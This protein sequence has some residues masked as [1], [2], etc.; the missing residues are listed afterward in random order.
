[1][2]LTIIS[3]NVGTG[4]TLLSTIFAAHT[5]KLVYANYE[6]KVKNY[7]EFELDKFLANKYNNCMIILDEA[8]V[9]L[10]SR[11]AMRNL[12]RVMSYL[13]FQSRKVGVDIILTAQLVSSLDVRYRDLC[14]YYITCEISKVGFNYK[15]TSI[16][17]KITKRFSLLIAKCQHY[18]G[19]YDTLERI[20]IVEDLSEVKDLITPKE[21]KM[22]EAQDYARQIIVKADM[23]GISRIT[24]DVVD[25]YSQ[26]L[27]IPSYAQ[28]L[29]YTCI[30]IEQKR[31]KVEKMKMAKNAT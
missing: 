20:N 13:L 25:Y 18:F 24:H 19:I 5:T 22:Q 27:N 9:Y 3:G 7:R 30:K 8:Y 6:I 12:N 23:E 10:E 11:I 4:K 28:K 14:E 15:I 31:D 1:M 16:A 2:V 21:R 26:I 29:V 17:R